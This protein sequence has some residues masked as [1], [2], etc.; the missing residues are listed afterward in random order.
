MHQ[1]IFSR[2]K[3]SVAS[4]S[5]APNGARIALLAAVSLLAALTAALIYALREGLSDERRT[6]IDLREFR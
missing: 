3:D 2:F 1:N 5:R 6:G 4:A